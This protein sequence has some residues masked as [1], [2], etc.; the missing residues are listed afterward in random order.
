ML[1]D[2]GDKAEGEYIVSFSVLDPE[3]KKNHTVIYKTQQKERQ[4]QAIGIEQ[5]VD[6][7]SSG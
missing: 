1:W 4:W 6:T 5:W 3:L 2:M 7:G